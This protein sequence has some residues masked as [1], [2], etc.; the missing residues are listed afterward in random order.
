MKSKQS[1]LGLLIIIAGVLVLLGNLNFGATRDIIEHWWPL[2]IVV[3]GLFML[4]SNPRNYVWALIVMLIGAMTLFR[5]LGIADF[6]ISSLVFPLIL[7]GLGLNIIVAANTSRRK[8]EFKNEDNIMAVLGGSSSR[9][10]SDNY[11][12]GSVS[13]FMGG[14]ELD[15]SKAVIKDQAVLTV[16]LIMG[17]LEVRVPENVRVV[18]RTQ[19]ILGG[20]EDKTRPLESKSTPTLVIEGMVLMGGIEIKR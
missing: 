18:N 5:A 12:G 15:L 16:S 3:A 10:T 2:A 11:T 8:A 19:S 7:V 9:N 14:A 13:A 6:S 1:I 17:G 4:W 20:I